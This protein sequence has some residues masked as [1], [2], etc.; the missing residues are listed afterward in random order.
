MRISLEKIPRDKKPFNEKNPH[1]KTLKNKNGD[2]EKK[3][4]EKRN[5]RKNPK[6]M[7]TTLKKN[8]NPLEK[9]TTALGGK[10]TFPKKNS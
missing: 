5:R 2:D 7:G 3:T 6:K 1:Q 10:K 8:I 4:F 9:K